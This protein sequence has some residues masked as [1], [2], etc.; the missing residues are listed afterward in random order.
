[1]M[2]FDETRNNFLTTIKAVVTLEYVER[3]TRNDHF[4]DNLLYV[5]PI[6]NHLAKDFMQ[7][8]RFL[9][10]ENHVRH[11]RKRILKGCKVIGTL[12][13]SLWECEFGNFFKKKKSAGRWWRTPLIP[14]LGRQSQADL[15]EFEA[16]LGYQVSPRKGAKLHRETLSQKK[17]KKKR[18]PTAFILPYNIG[19]TL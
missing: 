14:A 10:L 18:K 8:Q 15:C 13:H 17:K 2:D 5:W 9:V 7:K 1:L 11:L 12:I 16:R 3:A 6:L 4:S 19:I